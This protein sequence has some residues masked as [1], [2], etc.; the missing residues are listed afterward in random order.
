MDDLIDHYADRLSDE[1]QAKL[2]LEIR[3]AAEEA[4]ERSTGRS[5]SEHAA[6]FFGTEGRSRSKYDRLLL[7][8]I[9][10]SPDHQGQWSSL[11]KSA[12]ERAAFERRERYEQIMRQ[13]Q[14]QY[15]LA[16]QNIMHSKRLVASP[17]RPG[18]FRLR[19]GV[20]LAPW[21]LRLVEQPL[22]TELAI[23]TT[24]PAQTIDRATRAVGW[25][26]PPEGVPKFI[27]QEGTTVEYR[28]E[29]AA[30]DELHREV[31]RMHPRTADIWRLATAK[32]LQAWREG[33][34][35]PDAVWVDVRELAGAMGYT[36]KKAG[37]FRPELLQEIAKGLTD[38]ERMEV[39][40]PFGAWTFPTDP[41]TGKR[42]ATRLEAQ[43]SY[44]VLVVMARDEARDLFG[45]EYPLRWLLRLGPWVSAYPKQ[46]APLLGR[47][48]ELGGRGPENWAKS[49]GVE[50]IFALATAG[51]AEAQQVVQVKYLLERAG[52]WGPVQEM[53]QSRNLRRAVANFAEALNLLVSQGVIRSWRYLEAPPA[54]KGLA[55]WSS[56]SIVVEPADK[57]LE[58][59]Q[60]GVLSTGK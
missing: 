15:A 12:A 35:E 51:S 46:F 59:S 55:G 4:F 9:K 5:L 11:G 28:V 26:F 31:S 21:A 52:L 43:R 27:D 8:R 6:T 49:I 45:N 44:R 39:T 57:D 40:I 16:A 36:K 41:A 1:E 3:A 14:Q 48:V 13:Y 18:V 2:D 56:S 25:Q 42:K 23:M 34:N 24:N 10:E 17:N 53:E 22:P 20:Q 32:S 7:Q 60:M 33:A 30:I 38:L 54:R 50:I 58:G 29:G 19:A 37:V 47:L